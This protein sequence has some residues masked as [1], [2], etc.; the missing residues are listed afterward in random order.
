M[1]WE[2]AIGRSEAYIQCKHTLHMPECS[3]QGLQA[4]TLQPTAGS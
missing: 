4:S 1:H 3:Q 2:A